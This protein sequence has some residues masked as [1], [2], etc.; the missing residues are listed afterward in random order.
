MGSVLDDRLNELPRDE[1]FCHCDIH[2]DRCELCGQAIC[3]LAIT[4]R[5]GLC[6]W[7]VDKLPAFALRLLHAE[8]EGPGRI[9]A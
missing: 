8:L 2:P 7:C 5:E 3:C 1:F 6:L 4:R 9:T